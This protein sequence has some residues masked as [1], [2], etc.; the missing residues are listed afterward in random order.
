MSILYIEFGKGDRAMTTAMQKPPPWKAGKAYA[1][2]RRRVDDLLRGIN[3]KLAE[4]EADQAS[5]A[6]YWG[7]VA[8]MNRVLETLQETE[9]FLS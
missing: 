4:H 3:T 7:Y 5:N 9:E 6:H 2:A 8:D 1:E